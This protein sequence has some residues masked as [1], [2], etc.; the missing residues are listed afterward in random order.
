[1]SGPAVTITAIG[2]RVGSCEVIIRGEAGLSV[3]AEFRTE[4]EA[5]VFEEILGEALMKLDKL[6]RSPNSGQ[7]DPSA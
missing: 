6:A 3:S 7:R 5:M 2:H 4:I 1:M